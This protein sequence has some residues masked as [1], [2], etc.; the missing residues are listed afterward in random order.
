MNVAVSGQGPQ[1]EEE[2]LFS[3]GLPLQG[4]LLL[5]FVF[6]GNDL[7]DSAAWRRGSWTQELPWKERTLLNQLVVRAQSLTQAEPSYARSRTGWIGDEAYR[8]YWLRFSFE[9]L[10]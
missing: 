2:L 6:E 8:F 7:L 1:E 4:R 5:H 10:D 3:T 9:G